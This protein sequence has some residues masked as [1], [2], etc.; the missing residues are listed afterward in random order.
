M[1]SF[2]LLSTK[3][4]SVRLAVNRVKLL[5]YNLLKFSEKSSEIEPNGNKL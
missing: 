3:I 5:I 1:L 2:S 4:A